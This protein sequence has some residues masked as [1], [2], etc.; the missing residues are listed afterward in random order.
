M[1]R[2]PLQYLLFCIRE[3]FRKMVVDQFTGWTLTEKVA[4]L[5]GPFGS[6]GES[7]TGYGG[8]GR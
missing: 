6:W 3:V 8:G 4:K 1:P 7:A 5:G 2:G